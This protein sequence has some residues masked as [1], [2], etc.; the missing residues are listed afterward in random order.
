[1]LLNSAE[2]M[3]EECFREDAERIAAMPEALRDQLREYL[4]QLLDGVERPDKACLWLDQSTMKCR[5]HEH[6]PSICRDFEIGSA[7]CHSWR[8]AYG[9]DQ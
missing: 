3:A 5:H 9:I 1:M 6:R 2:M 8:D 4:R 7:E